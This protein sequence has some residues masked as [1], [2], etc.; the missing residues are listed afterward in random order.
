MSDK[1]MAYLRGKVPGVAPVTATAPP[2]STSAKAAVI[3]MKQIPSTF[4]GT[5]MSFFFYLSSSIFIIFLIL[6]FIHFAIYPIF[7][8]IAINPKK[9]T[10]LETAWIKAPPTSIEPARIKN[11][12]ST[13]FT[14]SF[15]VYMNTRYSG[16][17]APHVILY[18]SSASVPYTGTTT[19]NGLRSVFTSSN[20]LIYSDPNK[21]DIKVQ[22][23]K[24]SGYAETVATITNAPLGKT[25]RLTIVYM[26]TYIEVYMDGK[27]VSTHV[28]QGA[29]RTDTSDFWPPPTLM[30]DSVK[31]G[32]L[33]YWPRPL[34]V[35]EIQSLVGV[36]EK[37]RKFF[38]S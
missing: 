21:N 26:S 14:V 3:G 5:F 10:D 16:L 32:T 25:F 9:T 27:L 31:V 36:S 2:A 8:R 11:P 6:T 15:E 24:A 1:V 19:E 38:T 33:Y 13:D 34:S 28:L 4:T 29:P 35:V 23:I 20:L 17:Q 18:R 22:C 37:D 12:L 7:G 30:T